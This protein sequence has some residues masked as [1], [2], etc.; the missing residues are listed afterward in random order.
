MQRTIP[1]FIVQHIPGIKHMKVDS[2]VL[3]FTLVVTV[4]TGILAG[5]APALHVSNPDP[6]EA[7]KEGV[8]AQTLPPGAAAS[9]RAAGGHRGRARAGLA[10]GRRTYGE[11]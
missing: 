1:P 7:L 10:G 11:G 3:F 4:L 6:N 8:R 9:A 5:L 2:V